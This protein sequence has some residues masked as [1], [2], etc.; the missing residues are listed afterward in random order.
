[1]ALGHVF[2]I[3]VGK[4]EDKKGKKLIYILGCNLGGGLWGIYTPF[5]LK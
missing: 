2:P 4:K 5:K 3:K 1:V